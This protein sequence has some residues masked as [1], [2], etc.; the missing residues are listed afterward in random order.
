L[1][2]SQFSA[3]LCVKRRHFSREAARHFL[4]EIFALLI[5]KKGVYYKPNQQ[6]GYISIRRFL[7]RREPLVVQDLTKI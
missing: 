3:A 6:Y 7:S 1:F 4:P 5:F 2:F